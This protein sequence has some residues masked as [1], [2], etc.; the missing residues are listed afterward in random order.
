M[1]IVAWAALTLLV[2]AGPARAAV[3]QIRIVEVHTGPDA[4]Y[5]MLQM[6]AANQNGVSGHKVIVYNA[7]GSMVQSTTLGLDVS[8][9]D[10]QSTIL[11]GT[12]NVAFYFGITVDFDMASGAM[13]AAGGKVCFDSV[14]CVAWGNYTGSATGV[15]T[16]AAPGGIPA[17]KAIRRDLSISGGAMTLDVTD[18]TDVSSADFDVIDEPHPRNNLN[19]VGNTTT[20]FGGGPTT[21]VSTSTLAPG[22]TTTLVSGPTTTS[23]LPCPPI[24]IGAAQCVLDEIPPAE[25]A[26]DTFAQKLARTISAAE[27]L[28]DRASDAAGTRRG[29]RLVKRAAARLRKASRQATAAAT[30]QKLSAACAATLSALLDTARERVLANLPS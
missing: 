22:A 7:A 28:L 24:G 3:D 11:V 13:S 25:C 4:Q 10:D 26:T 19:Q 27:I 16:P 5:V 8:S 1:R 9:G 17:G 30:K 18:D 15:G 20:T 6:A 23:T 29:V 21:T 12:S 14:D 2:W